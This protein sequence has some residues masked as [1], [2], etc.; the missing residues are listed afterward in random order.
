M[1]AKQD[2]ERAALA[3]L[4]KIAKGDTGQS[5]RVADFLLAWWNAGS[6]GSFDLTSLWALDR[7]I[8]EDMTV[9][10]GLIGQAGNYPDQLDPALGQEF[11]AIIAQ[12]RSACHPTSAF[13]VPLMTCATMRGTASFVM[14]QRA[15]SRTSR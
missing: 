3:R 9:V 4:I 14:A 15:V 13:A 8:V 1:T 11:A 6:C 2:N 10:F 12:W 5:R 7:A